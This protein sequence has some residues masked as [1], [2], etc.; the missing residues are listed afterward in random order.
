MKTLVGRLNHTRIPCDAGRLVWHFLRTDQGGHG[1]RRPPKAQ[2]RLP[3]PRS[4]RSST[5]VGG[6]PESGKQGTS[7]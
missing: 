7:N 5:V 4:L 6:L 2:H 3:E 1:S